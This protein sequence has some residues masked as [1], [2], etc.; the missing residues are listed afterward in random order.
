[1]KIKQI[2]DASG[3][4]ISSSDSE[5]ESLE[6]EM[7]RDNSLMTLNKSFQNLG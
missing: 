5:I 1:M 2:L 7:V 6:F 4:P 3:R